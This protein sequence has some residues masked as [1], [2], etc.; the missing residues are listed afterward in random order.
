MKKVIA[1]LFV[2][3]LSAPMFVGSVYARSGYLSDFNNLY[4][5]AATRLDDCVLCHIDKQT[6]NPYGADVEAGILSGLSASA[7][8]TAIESTD[9]DGDGYKNI[10]EISA[11]SF[12]GDAG[13]TPGGGTTCTDNDSDGFAV[14]GGNCGLVDCNDNDPLV[15]PGANEVC[16]DGID[17]N[18]DGKV[19]CQDN[20]C[21]SAPA[22]IVCT[23]NDGDGYAVEGGD[24]GPIDCNDNDLAVHPG[25]IENCTDGLDNDCDNL[26]DCV[27]G[28]CSVVPACDNVCIPE[29]AQEKGKKCSDGLD[30]DCDGVIDGADPDC[31]GDTGGSEGKGKTCSDGLDNDGD[32]LVDCADSDCAGNRVCK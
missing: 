16:D 20:T 5:T 14:E 10:D 30:N 23:D 12:P 13:D 31:G 18:C 25:A 2:A 11:L 29:S 1:V 7:A 22:C 21:G 8:M 15:N 24:C 32:G 17:N 26:I 9:S 27:D 6:R 3:L 28:D 19:D 4:G